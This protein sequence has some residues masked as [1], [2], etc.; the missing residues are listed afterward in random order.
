MQDQQKKKEEE[1][2]EGMLD[3]TASSFMSLE[4]CT[5][6]KLCGMGRRA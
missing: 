1:Q 6:Q 5:E 4:H 3:R 2:E